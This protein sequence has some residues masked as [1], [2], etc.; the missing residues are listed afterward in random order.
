M[1]HIRSGRPLRDK[2][3]IAVLV[4]MRSEA[5]WFSTET[6][7]RYHDGM[8]RQAE[9][10]GFG[11]EFF[12]LGKQGMRPERVDEILYARGVRGLVLAAP[13]RGYTTRVVNVRWERYACVTTGYSWVQP[14]DRVAN[15]QYGNVLIAYAELIK[16]GYRRIGMILSMENLRA[17]GS[18][19]L[20]GYAQSEQEYFGGQR[21]PV[22]FYSPE[23]PAMKAFGA[24]LCEHRPEAV[25][26]LMGQELE[27]LHALKMRVPED[28]GLVTVIRSHDSA[29][30]GVEERN[31]LIGAITLEQVA[32]QIMRNEQGLPVQARLTLVEGEWVEGKT[33]RGAN[34]K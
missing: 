17:R 15:D 10:L 27:W 11:L 31:E 6:Y 32:A 26:T 30:T 14:V 19:W 20:G 1:S 18:R 28:V 12:F 33:L 23:Q 3:C 25:I 24:W 22:F 16:R 13:F 9:G 21:M 5:D 4:D 34:N 29:C 7:R 2:G 8:A